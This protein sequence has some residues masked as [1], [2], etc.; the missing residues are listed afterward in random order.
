MNTDM[1]SRISALA[2][3]DPAVIYAAN[4]TKTSAII[5]SAG[6]ESL[7]FIAIAGVLTDGTWTTALYGGDASNMSDEVIL[8]A[9]EYIGTLP[10]F[11]ITDDSVA[12]RV[13][14]NIAQV[15][16]RYYRMKM[17]QAAAPTGGYMAAC[18]ILA[19]PRYAPVAG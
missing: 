4:G 9:S 6:F 15:K 3:I 13:G 19:K 16:K 1:N 7:E 18:A 12:K 11:A 14:V 5:D 10:S 8:A 2:A 17:T